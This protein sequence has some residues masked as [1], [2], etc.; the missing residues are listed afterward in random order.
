MLFPIH[1][2][3]S[4]RTLIFS[5]CCV[6][7]IRRPEC[8]RVSGACPASSQNHCTDNYL[9]VSDA[10]EGR[11]VT[12]SNYRLELKWQRVQAPAHLLNCDKWQ[13]AKNIMETPAG[14]I[15]HTMLKSH[16]IA[17]LPLV[18]SLHALVWLPLVRS[19]WYPTPSCRQSTLN[20]DLRLNSHLN[21]KPNY[22]EAN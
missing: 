17:C 1:V 9:T 15:Y 5:R 7:I 14:C 22:N 2:V 13:D 8:E 4:L 18:R 21:R 19:W 12:N 6:Y 10:M 20:A 3:S 16:A 11:V